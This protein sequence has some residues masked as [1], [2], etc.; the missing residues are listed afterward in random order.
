MFPWGSGSAT[1]MTPAQ[2]SQPQMCSS[3]WTTSM[4]WNPAYSLQLSW[5]Q[6]AS[7]HFWTSSSSKTQMAPPR[8]MY[9]GKP[10][11]RTVT[12]TL[13]PTTHWPTNLQWSRHCMARQKQSAQ[14]WPQRTRIPGT[15]DRP[16]S[17][18]VSQ[19][20]AAAS[21]Y[22]SPH[23]TCR[24]PYVR[25]LSEA[26]RQVL[27]SLGLRVSFRSN[28]TL[29]QLLVR[30][31]D[32]ITTEELAGVVYQVSCA[33]CPAFYVGQTGRWLGKW[34][35]ED[36]KAVESG[37]CAYAVLADHSW[38]HPVDWN[39]VRILEQEP[40]LCHRLTLESIHIRSHP[41]TLNRNDGTLSP[42]Y[43]PC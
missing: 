10:P 36:R 11:T 1:W 8:W 43:T 7:S 30:P 24:R 16:L 25:G 38:S 3:S 35:K 5:N 40:H 42:V 18:T 9:I 15:S 2:H 26:V 20:G 31:K 19:R 39:K 17:T 6:T 21:C 41:H 22:T 28:S 29:K 12:S 4:G 32:R 33:S 27:T 23:E 13:C 34:M 14:T 37:Q